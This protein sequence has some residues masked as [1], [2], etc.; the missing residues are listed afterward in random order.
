MIYSFVLDDSLT[1]KRF[2]M[3][4]EYL[5]KCCE[6]L[7][8]RVKLGACQIGITDRFKAIFLLWF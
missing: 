3:G 1:S 2:T 8:I 6:P 7:R 5:N 4:T